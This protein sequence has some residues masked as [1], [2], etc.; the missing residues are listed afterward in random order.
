M[1]Y[2][3]LSALIAGRK[4]FWHWRLRH[5][6]QYHYDHHPDHNQHKHYSDHQHQAIQ[7][8]LGHEN[9]TQQVKFLTYML[10]LT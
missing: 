7:P 6:D 1:T 8:G 3:K 9:H 10:S 4:Y 5:P 2:L